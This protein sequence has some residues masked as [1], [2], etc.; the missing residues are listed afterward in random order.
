MMFACNGMHTCMKGRQTIADLEGHLLNEFQKSGLSLNN[1]CASVSDGGKN[2]VG[3]TQTL[4]DDREKNPVQ[5]KLFPCSILC[6]FV[7]F[8]SALFVLAIRSILR[9]SKF[10]SK[11]KVCCC[12]SSSYCR[13]RGGKSGK[14][15]VG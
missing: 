5:L 2:F 3:A 1:V 4:L 10:S 12:F 14:E 11:R 7:F 9:C 15:V 8:I 6:R 13:R